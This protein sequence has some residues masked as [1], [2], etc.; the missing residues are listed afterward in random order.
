MNFTEL[1]LDENLL[2]GIQDTGFESLMPVQESTFPHTLKGKDVTVQSQTGTGKTAAFLISIFQHFSSPDSKRKKKALVIAPTRE[3]A[4]QIEKE[5][6]ELGRHLNFKIGSFYGGVGYNQQERHLAEGVNLMIGT[7]GRLLDFNSKGKL[8]FSDL[9]FLVIDEADRLFDMGFLPDI[10]RILRSS[11]SSNQRQ[12]ML[13]SAT[14]DVQTRFIGREFMNRPMKV[15]IQPDMITVDKISQSLYHV[16][17]TEKLNL[18]LGIMKKE[19]PNNALIF[20][21]MKHVAAQV[22]KHLEYNGYKC[23]HISGDLPQSKRL[24]VIED[25]K[26]GKLP[27]LVAT[28]VAAR[29]L[30][31]DDLELIINYDLPGDCENYVH[32]IGRTARAGKSGKAISLA[33]EDFVFNLEAIE[34]YIGMKIPVE[35]A[36]DNLYEESKSAGMNFDTHRRGGD[37]RKRQ[38][39]SSHSKSAPRPSK[40]GSKKK[41]KPETSDKPDELKKQKSAPKPKKKKS[42]P[43]SAVED[44]AANKRSSGKKSQAKGSQAKGPQ[45]KGP[46]AKGPRKAQK[47]SLD[48]RIEYYKKKYGDNFTVPGTESAQKQAKVQAQAVKQVPQPKKSFMKKLKSIFKKK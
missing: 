29:G 14:L 39:R 33:C 48:E 30:H 4:V 6:K 8:D 11:G 34:S 10:K 28:D 22:S 43:P 47:H 2:K 1:N 3:L 35:F 32:R 21:N 40:Y 12:T 45:A 26:S 13:F 27:I 5:A 9:G 18:L 7:P 46:Q 25:F 15:E 16:S 19:L 37:D 41:K 36:E 23:L 17:Q 44:K 31:I 38:K 24:R 42:P 20:T